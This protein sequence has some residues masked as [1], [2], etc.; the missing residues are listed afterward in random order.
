MYLTTHT[1]THTHT[2]THTSRTHR[3]VLWVRMMRYHSLESMCAYV[4]VY[5][6]GCD[7]VLTRACVW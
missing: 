1:H 7:C 2:R 5:V 6:G 3:M 4:C